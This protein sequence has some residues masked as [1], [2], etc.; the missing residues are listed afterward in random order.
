MRKLNNGALAEPRLFDPVRLTV[1]VAGFALLLTVAVAVVPGLHFAYRDEALHLRLEA[2]QGT[3]G[4]V[5]AFL[6]FGRFRQSRS[7]ED[8]AICV[9]LLMFSLTNLVVSPLL[10]VRGSREPPSYFV[11]APVMVRTVGASLFLAG[12]WPLRRRVERADRWLWFSVAGAVFVIAAIIAGTAALSDVLPVGLRVTAPLPDT[13]RARVVG[14]PLLLVAQG[15]QLM[16]FAGAAVRLTWRARYGD[17]L[18][19]WFGAA[20][21]LAAVARL[22]YLIFPSLYTRYVYIGDM[23]RLGFYALLLI[24]AAREIRGFW[25]ARSAAAVLDER[26]RIARDLHDGLAHEL[27]F[28]AAQSRRIDRRGAQVGELEAVARASERALSDARRA[29]AALTRAIDEPLDK[30]IEEVTEHL[31]SRAGAEHEVNVP[32]IMVPSGFR[33]ELVRILGESINNATRHGGATHIAVHVTAGDEL[34]MTITDNGSG[35]ETSQPRSK[36]SFGLAS[37]QER[38]EALNGTFV[39][40][41]RSGEGTRVEVCLPL[42][43]S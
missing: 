42:P 3:I 16:M 34:R 39:V 4:L 12:A 27:V 20:A 30:T 8:L 18:L 21:G 9:A 22:N 5:A 1:F 15:V 33:E 35:F 11:W 7:A 2:V 17:E 13:F 32:R 36:W 25:E 28:V 26:R 43:T 38:A 24:G 29:I 41:S 6:M 23:M 37:M 40:T 31:A 14:H 10:D 19:G